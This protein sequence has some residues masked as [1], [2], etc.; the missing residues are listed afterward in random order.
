[1]L[2]ALSYPAV[3]EPEDQTHANIQTA[4][5]STSGHEYAF[6]R[7]ATQPFDAKRVQERA[8][9][10]WEA[11][12]LE[13]ITLHECRH[14]FAILMIA[15]G[16]NVSALK[17][18]M[19]HANINT[20]IDRYGHLLPGGEAEAADLLDEYLVAQQ[21]QAEERAREADPVQESCLTG[22]QTG[23]QQ[24]AVAAKPLA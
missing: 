2:H 11:A 9:K 6:G 16:V 24:E 3:L 14:T 10:A 8:D 18:F 15:S 13:R 23:E 4:L 7:T 21:R 22:E 19:G 5:L 20:T 12:G 17:V 1:V